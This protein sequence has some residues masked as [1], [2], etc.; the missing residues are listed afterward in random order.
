MNIVK[1]AMNELRSEGLENPTASDIADY[2]RIRMNGYV[3]IKTID[4]ILR[5]LLN[6]IKSVDPVVETI[7]SDRG[8]P[9]AEIIQKEDS[10]EFCKVVMTL[11]ERSRLFISLELDYYRVHQEPLSIK[12]A[13]EL[14][15]QYDPNA[16][17]DLVAKLKK[18][19]E[20]ELARKFRAFTREE[21]PLNGVS[22]NGN[23]RLMEM[24]EDD[25][26]AAV[27]DDITIIEF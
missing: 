15:R 12:T 1:R 27:N 26:I 19:S 16:S 24:E 13:T 21:L 22:L 20:R 17:R 2:I 7:K 4:N 14:Y 25:I 9:V 11:S 10:E 18:A 5:T 3:P 6:P 8:D 23:L